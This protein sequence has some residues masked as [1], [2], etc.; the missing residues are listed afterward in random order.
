MELYTLF[1]LLNRLLYSYI[2][3]DPENNSFLEL[4]HRTYTMY[5]VHQACQL[6][7]VLLFLGLF[8]LSDFYNFWFNH[9]ILLLSYY[10]AY[11]FIFLC[12]GIINALKNYVFLSTSCY[13]NCLYLTYE[14]LLYGI[15][16]DVSLVN[17]SPVRMRTRLRTRHTQIKCQ[18]LSCID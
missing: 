4:D 8:L 7:S 18:V 17:G 2:L 12:S 1:R 14:T 5:I 15:C 11:L 10:F 16:A 3:V 6:R 13:R 9:S